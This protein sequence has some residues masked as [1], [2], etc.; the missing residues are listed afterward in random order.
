MKGT[1]QPEKGWDSLIYNNSGEDVPVDT[2]VYFM[3]EVHLNNGSAYLAYDE[4]RCSFVQHNRPMFTSTEKPP[5]RLKQR[6]ER[7]KH[8]TVYD[9]LRH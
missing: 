5:V 3:L 6:V 1:F 2:K 8:E 7:L 4:T 9:Y